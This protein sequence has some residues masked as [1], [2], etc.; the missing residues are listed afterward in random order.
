MGGRTDDTSN[1]TGTAPQLAHIE[2]V[3]SWYSR[4]GHAGR[5]RVRELMRN[6]E[7]LTIPDTPICDALL[8]GKQSRDCLSDPSPP[9]PSQAT[10]S[11]ATLPDRYRARIQDAG[12]LCCLLI[13]TVGMLRYLR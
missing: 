3:D 5:D 7:L 1:S 6:G 2:V 4:L 8:R 13:S 9:Q 11:T 10:S 12:S